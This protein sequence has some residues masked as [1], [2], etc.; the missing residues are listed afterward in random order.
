IFFNVG[1]RLCEAAAANVFLVIDGELR[2]PNISSGCL[3]GV[4]RSLVLESAARDGLAC[5]EQDLEAADLERAEA[6]FLTSATRGPVAVR[7][8]DARTYGE[9]G[10]V[11]RVAELWRQAVEAM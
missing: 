1:G 10:V 2:T 8:L 4:A 9:S 11:R 6:M 7:R 5:R 3:P